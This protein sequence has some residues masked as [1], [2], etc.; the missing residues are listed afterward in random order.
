MKITSIGCAVAALLVSTSG[1]ATAQ[2]SFTALQRALRPGDTVYV[3]DHS[4]A[5]RHGSVAAVGPSSL[6]LTLDGVERE[7]AE[8]DV[9]EVRRRGDSVKNGAIIGMIGGGVMGGIGGSLVAQLFVNE[10]ASGTGP[11]LS[12]LA[13]GMAGGAGIG[14]AIDGLIPGRTV[15]YRQPR[16]LTITPVVAPGTR[17]VQ[18]GSSFP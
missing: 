14:A 4:G 2:E 18:V 15:V 8:A 17:A 6:K 13:L 3:T 16:G 9:R 1:P 5:E 7:W 12:F 11:F 10:G